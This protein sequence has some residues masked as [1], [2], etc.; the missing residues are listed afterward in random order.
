MHI[1]VFSYF[2]LISVVS[3]HYVNVLSIA[4]KFFLVPILYV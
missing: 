4:V 3:R 1:F 2:I